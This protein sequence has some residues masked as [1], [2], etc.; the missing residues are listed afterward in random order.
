MGRSMLTANELHK[1]GRPCIDLHNYYIQNYKSGQDILVS[2]KD[3][4]FLVGDNIFILTFTNLYDLFNLDVMDLSNA[5]FRVV[6]P[7]KLAYSIYSIYFLHVSNKFGI[8]C[9]GTCNNKLIIKREK[10][11]LHILTRKW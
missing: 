3:H 10:R 11:L 7:E 4:H 8:L 9:V 2:Y 6:G 1:A 5:L